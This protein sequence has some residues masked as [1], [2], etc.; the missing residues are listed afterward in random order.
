MTALYAA[1]QCPARIRA[2]ELFSPG[3]VWE[4]RVPQARLY[5]RLP[6]IGGLLGGRWLA[7]ISNRY[8][9]RFLPAWFH[10]AEPNM[11]AGLAQGLHLRKRR[12]L[13]N[14]FRGMASSDFP[15]RETLAALE[16]IATLIL[17]WVG[18]R[19]HPVSSAEELHRISDFVSAF[20]LIK[21]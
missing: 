4:T 5:R 17:A 14:L 9:D 15:P 16:E 3:T 10:Q 12:T 2:L 7:A 19:N 1:L 8:A 20:V 18:D 13:W 21:Q 11:I 6:I